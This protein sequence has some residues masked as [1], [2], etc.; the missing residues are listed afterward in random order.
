MKTLIVIFI[1]FVFL[2][3]SALVDGPKLSCSEAWQSVDVEAKLLK[4]APNTAKRLSKHVLEVK[5]ATGIKRFEDKPPYEDLSG[6]R[7]AYCGYDAEH[8][9]HLIAKSVESLFTGIIILEE[10]GKIL[11]A[12][13]TVLVSPDKSKYLAV[14]Q[15]DGL[16]GENWKLFDFSGKKIWGGYAGII[17]RYPGNDFDSVY[18]QY[19]NPV[20]DQESNL[21][22]DV[23]CGSGNT[24]GGVVLKLKNKGWEWE[25]IPS[26]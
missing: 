15:E 25:P 23:T 26:C 5:F 18:A 9:F 20:W 24:A 1:P 16:D 22:A 6:T 3:T 10:T 13:H 17:R 11:D 14:E 7:W 21:K 12:G 2:S 4:L 8:K 19:E